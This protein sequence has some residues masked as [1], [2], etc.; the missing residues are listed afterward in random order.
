MIGEAQCGMQL[1]LRH[2]TSDTAAICFEVRWVLLVR[3]AAQA[4]GVVEARVS[5]PRVLMRRMASRTFDIA[6]LETTALH[7]P[8]G[9]EANVLN[10]KVVHRW[11]VPM[12]GSAKVDLLRRA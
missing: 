8:Q 7:Q 5:T 3:M 6:L 4:L 1:D 2:V 10:L 9:L 12:T 11:R